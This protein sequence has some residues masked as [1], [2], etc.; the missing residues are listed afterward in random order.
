MLVNDAV[1]KGSSDGRR[2]GGVREEVNYRDA[3]TSN[4]G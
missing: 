3:S 1:D 4:Y 2:E